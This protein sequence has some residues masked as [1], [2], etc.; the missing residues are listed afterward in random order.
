V[1]QNRSIADQEGVLRDLSQRHGMGEDGAM[2]EIIR[3][4]LQSKTTE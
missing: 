4:N 1:S 3:H 2:A